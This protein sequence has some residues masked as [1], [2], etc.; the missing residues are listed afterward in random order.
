MTTSTSPNAQNMT[1]AELRR[2][3]DQRLVAYGLTTTQD[4]AMTYCDHTALESSPATDDDLKKL[5]EG[6]ERLL[7][8]EGK[9]AFWS[10]IGTNAF[11]TALGAALGVLLG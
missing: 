8:L 1:I 4:C 2:E 3:V 10:G 11:F 9:R 5:Q 7:K 6:L